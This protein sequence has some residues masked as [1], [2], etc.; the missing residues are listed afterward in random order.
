[1]FRKAVMCIAAVVLLQASISSAHDEAVA[2]PDDPT[3]RISFPDTA[4]YHTLVLDP[5]THSS[6]SDGHVWP[7]IRIEEALRD[8]LDAIAITEH[9]C[10]KRAF[11]IAA[12][13]R[14]RPIAARHDHRS[15]GQPSA[16]TSRMEADCSLRT[17]LPKHP[18]R[19]PVGK[20][21]PVHLRPSAHH[22]WV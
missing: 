2:P 15:R 6:F 7:R 16:W 11:R 20:L 14:Q 1:M 13:D 4:R 12:R 19:T 8:G 21:V 9:L 22:R 5:H 10:R 18:N 17:P 3:R